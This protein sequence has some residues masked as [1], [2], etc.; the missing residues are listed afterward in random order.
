MR[1]EVFMS[2]LGGQG[3]M[4]AGQVLAQAALDAG[5]QIS[6]FPS[7]SPE[8][9]G[10]EAN[11]TLVLSD[12]RVGSPITGRPGTVVL[13]APAAVD[14][15][16]ADCAPGGLAIINSGLGPVEITRDDLQVARVDASALAVQAGGERM[17]NMVML[18]AWLA[19]ACPELLETAVAALTTVLPD[20]HHKWIPSNAQAIR[21]GAA[22]ASAESA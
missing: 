16:L 22:A 19:L 17:A 7:Y 13:M 2:G 10:G 11:C 21:L 12:G 9:R 5:L 8:V 6:W 18:G 1:Q 20:R 4:L 14:A 3:I 15:Y